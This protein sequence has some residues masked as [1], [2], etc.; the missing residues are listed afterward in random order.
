[1]VAEPRR[2]A[3]I[4]INRTTA[5]GHGTVLICVNDGRGPGGIRLA[6]RGAPVT[7]QTLHVILTALARDR[8]PPPATVLSDLAAASQVPLDQVHA[9][10][11]RIQNEDDDAIRALRLDGV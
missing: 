3:L 11:Q 6:P 5:A 8:D 1:M 2:R 9:Q 10:I 7:P 4:Q